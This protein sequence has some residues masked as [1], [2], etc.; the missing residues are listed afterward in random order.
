[1]ANSRTLRM[2]GDEKIALFSNMSTMLGAGIPIAETVE[3]LLD[4]AKGA[5]RI[6]LTQLRD[7]LTAGHHVSRTFAQFPKIFDKVTVNLTKAAEESGTLET[8]L[9]DV[10]KNLRKQMELGD[11]VKS[12]MM[13]PMLV[14]VVFAGVLLVMLLVVIPKIAKVFERLKVELALPTK[15][16]IMLSNTLINQPLLVLSVSVVVGLLSFAFYWYKREV[17]FKVLFSLP[18]ISQLVRQMDVSYFARSMYLLLSSGVPMVMSLE[19]AEEVLRKAEMRKL[20]KNARNRTVAGYPFSS[21]LRSKQKLIPEMM[22]KLMEV[23]EKTGTLETSM[24]SIADHMDYQVAKGL[25]K[26]TTLLEPLMLVTVAV[27]VGGMMMAII[28]PIYGLI[29]QVGAM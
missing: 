21:S 22:I 3:S 5:K 18:G 13:Y 14:M 4:E 24:Q 9:K 19:L 15:L 29:S 23:G 7:D 17:F 27:V 2:S 25:S 26:A 11:K 1:M 12:A 16:M 6:V 8:T 20:V 28:S 10:E